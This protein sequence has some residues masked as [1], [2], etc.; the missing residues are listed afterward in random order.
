MNRLL[1]GLA[2]TVALAVPAGLMAAEPL[3]V[4]PKAP[5]VKQQAK[6]Q[7]KEQEQVYGSQLM[8]QKERMEHRAQLRAAKTVQEREQIRKAH[9]EKMQL[10]AKEKGVTLPDMPAM[11][12]GGGMMGPRGGM[13]PKR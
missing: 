2:V 9:H 12:A 1:T 10:R 11:P 7:V 6:E 13:G 4:A 5:D 3:I 8:T